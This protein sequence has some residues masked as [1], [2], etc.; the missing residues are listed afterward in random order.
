MPELPEVESVRRSLL[1]LVGARI[2]DV[3]LLRRTMLVVPGDP[4]GGFERQRTPPRPRRYSRDMLL[5]GRTIA[6]IDRRGKRLALRTHPG[7]G[8]TPCL[9]AHLGMTGSFA[10]L[11][12]GQRRPAPL[13]DHVHALWTLDDGRRLLFRDPRRFGGLRA[14][15]DRAD[16]DAAW[17]RLGPDALSIT[18]D[19][20]HARLAP[21]ARPLKAALLDQTLLAG[22]GNIYADEAC[23]AARLDPHHRADALSPAQTARLA[24]AIRG[25]LSRSIEA[26]GSTLRDF[27]AADGSVGSYQIAGHAVYAR[28]GLPCPRCRRP[29]LGCVLAQRATVWCPGCQTGQT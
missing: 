10:L 15:T 29:L 11:A 19:A 13:R 24:D 18:P 16:L 6:D 20:L 22:V 28:A 8:Q 3:R 25:I 27:A 5:L 2:V 14:F 12:P 17:A 23:F 26:G 1:P 4:P 9:E 21:A 7:R